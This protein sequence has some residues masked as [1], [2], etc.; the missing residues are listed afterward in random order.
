MVRNAEG[1]VSVI[2]GTAYVEDAAHPGM[3][4]APAVAPSRP[5]EFIMGEFQKKGR[6]SSKEY[7]GTKVTPPPKDKRGTK[8][9]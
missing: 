6:K 9:D 7:R 1:E 8:V 4:V 2:G 5:Y 3:L